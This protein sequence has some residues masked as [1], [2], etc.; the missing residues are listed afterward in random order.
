MNEAVN[1]ANVDSLF[2]TYDKVLRELA[3]KFAPA[4]V[5]KPIRCQRI[6][7]WFEDE[8]RKLRRRSRMLE[9]RFRRTKSPD[10]CLVWVQ[11]EREQHRIYR[12]KEDGYWLSRVAEYSS[13]PRKLW[14][15][16][17]SVMGIENVSSNIPTGSPSAQS[18]ID[19]FVKKI[20]DI[21]S[22]T[23]QSPPTTTLPE[24]TTIF[25]S[26]RT[27]SVAEVRKVILS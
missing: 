18:L 10:D 21:R 26:F 9:R 2:N 6:A 27:Y 16:F 4:R 22:S 24:A 7:V 5:T 15:R 20:E 25:T 11:H 14:K 12:I 19:Y 1:E 23:G 17:S 13:Q 8:C 3:D